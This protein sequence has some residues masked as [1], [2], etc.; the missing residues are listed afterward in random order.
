MRP[1]ARVAVAVLPSPEGRAALA[2]AS[3]LASAL[4]TPLRVLMVLNDTPGESAARE[5][6]RALAPGAEVATDRHDATS[7][8]APAIAAATA[9][10]QGR[11][12]QVDARILVGDPVDA[13]V[14]SSAEADVLL[15][16]SRAYGPA[17][18]V[19]AGG[20]AR[21]VLTRAHCPVVLIPRKDPPTAWRRSRTSRARMP[22][23]APTQAPRRAGMTWIPAGSF[24]M[25]SED[26]YPEE[27]PVR[28][29]EVDGFWIDTHPV[30][31]A[32]FRRFVRETGHVT[33]AERAPDAAEYPDAD[34]MLLVPGS[35]LFRPTRGPVP[36]DDWQRWWHYVPGACWRR[37]EGPGSD[38]YSRARHPVVHV[39]FEDA[40][41]YAAW[42]GAALPTEAEWEY[43]ARGGLDG[44]TYAWGDEPDPRMAN[45]WQGD[46]PWRGHRGTSPVGAHP[47]NG[48]GLQDMIGNVWEWTVD[49]FD[50]ATA[51]CHGEPGAHIP[52]RV[53]KGGSHLCAPSYCLRYRPAARQG[54]AV[55]TS[56]SHLGFRCVVRPSY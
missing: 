7:I 16:G 35:L 44:A 29:A 17:D 9:D 27:G 2:A 12:L 48:Y 1:L 42:A 53:I 52:R 19:L 47:P 5:V 45:T 37:P 32:Q 46:F 31:V 11:P 28:R 36:L 18:T 24:R 20:V 23:L 39:A 55:D 56:T 49:R 41:A 33:E 30:T 26:F 15:L 40:Q 4:G 50:A 14:R 21:G 22:E 6:A 10:V 38:T 54:E 51:A 25:G 34:P 8:L 13:I 43:A 3:R